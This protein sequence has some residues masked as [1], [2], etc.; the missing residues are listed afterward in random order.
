MK[1]KLV[2]FAAATIT[3]LSIATTITVLFNTAPTERSVIWLAYGSLFVSMLGIA[4]LTLYTISYQRF[5]LPPPMQT[6]G[7]LLRYSILFG[8]AVVA[9]LALSA[10][11]SLN[12]VVAVI[13]IA[14]MGLADLLWRRR[15]PFKVSKQ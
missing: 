7:N 3:L 9:L 5:K 6:T 14:A 1:N 15:T 10:N 12:W 13:V 8:L 2:L 4:F 11:S